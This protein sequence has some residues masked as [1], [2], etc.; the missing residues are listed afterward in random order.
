[1]VF[2][3]GVPSHSLEMNT[4][5][6]NFIRIGEWLVLFLIRHIVV[7]GIGK[8]RGHVYGVV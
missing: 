3:F 4:K 7:R 5:Q 8:L 6:Q 2:D 1:M